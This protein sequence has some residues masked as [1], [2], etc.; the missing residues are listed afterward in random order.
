MTTIF[1]HYSEDEDYDGWFDT[2]EGRVLFR[3]EVEAVRLLMKDIK[4]PFL[5]IGVGTGRF[6]K[7]LGI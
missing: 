2:P 3:M 6:A 7:E 5:E 1:N 4:R